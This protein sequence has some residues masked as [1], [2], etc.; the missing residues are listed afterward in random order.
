MSGVG[1]HEDITDDEVVEVSWEV[2]C[3]YAHEALSNAEFGNLNNVISCLKNV[4]SI[5]E[6]ESNVGESIDASAGL[7]NYDAFNKWVDKG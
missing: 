7:V 2:V 4:V 3:H 6:G 1:A 5:V